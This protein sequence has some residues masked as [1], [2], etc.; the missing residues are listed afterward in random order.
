MPSLLFVCTGNIC[1]SPMA[2]AL[3]KQLLQQHG[4]LASW[5]V[6]SAGTWGPSGEP[7]S[8]NACLVMVER[9]YDLSQHRSRTVNGQLLKDFDLILVMERGHVEALATEFPEIAGR[10]HLLTHVVDARHDIP[11]PYLQDVRRYREMADC[12]SDVLQRGF[13]R[14]VALAA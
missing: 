6:E 14:I 3:F 9:G 10:L 13:Q 4:L 8:R 2:V 5:R 11:D 7:A 1:R 12:L